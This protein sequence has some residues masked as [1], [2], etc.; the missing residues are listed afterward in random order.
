MEALKDNESIIPVK[1]QL[2]DKKDFRKVFN[3]IFIKNLP[4]GYDKEKVNALFGKFGHIKDSFVASNEKGV[5]AF[6]CYES[7]D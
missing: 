4:E 3:N 5:F 2:K 1:F 6:V 7:P